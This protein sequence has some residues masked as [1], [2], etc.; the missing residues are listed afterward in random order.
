METVANN[1]RATNNPCN[2]SHFSNN[3]T[4]ENSGTEY[5]FSTVPKVIGEGELVI[6]ENCVFFNHPDQQNS[7]SEP[8]ERSPDD[9]KCFSAKSRKRLFNLFNCLQYSAYGLPAFL[10]CTFHYDSPNYRAELKNILQMFVYRLK[11]CLPE[12]HYIWKFEYQKRG[13]PHFHFILFP[14]DKKISMF[15]PAREI[16]IKNHWLQLKKCHCKSCEEYSIKTVCCKTHKMSFSYIAKE[17]AKVQDNYLDHDLGRIWGCSNNMRINHLFKIPCSVKN[18]E[19]IIDRKL[20]ENFKNENQ[21]LYINGIRFLKQ[22]SS[23]FIDHK[24]IQD[25]ILQLRTDKLI[26]GIKTNQM[27]LKRIF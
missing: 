20:E 13:A 22:N 17:I 1:N 27:K 25:I 18:Y 15:S 9:I 26:P 23:I 6:F 19:K 2:F 4:S 7:Y 11:R 3:Q 24:K 5:V 12:F 14:L 10:S 8:P 21:K 16:Q